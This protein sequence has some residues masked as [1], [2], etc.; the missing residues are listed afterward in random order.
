L[1]L[2]SDRRGGGG[3]ENTFTR[4]APTAAL[5][6]ANESAIVVPIE[7]PTVGAPLSSAPSSPEA[8]AAASADVAKLLPQLSLEIRAALDGSLQKEIAALRSFLGSTLDTHAEK[9][10][11][12]LATLLPATRIPQLDMPTVIPERRSF[13]TI[14]GWTL[15]LLAL[16]GGG[17]MSWQWW[18]QG[19][20][21]AALHTDLSAALAE[22]ETLRARP[23]VV[24]PAVLV[25]A[26]DAAALPGDAAAA[27]T[28]V[29]AVVDGTTPQILS[30]VAVPTTAAPTVAPLSAAPPTPAPAPAST[31]SPAQ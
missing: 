21:I 25:P 10:Q 2:V 3:E 13:A 30:P 16:A 5:T 26:A 14:A 15:A 23:E 12:D 27:G 17:F 9:I 11:G 6:S 4:V 18:Q 20:E 19:A 31:P 8:T 7:T 28:A 29:T 22:A 1:R 24:S